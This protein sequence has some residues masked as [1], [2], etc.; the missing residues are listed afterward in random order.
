[1]ELL[2]SLLS[3]LSALD[4][5]TLDQEYSGAS[6]DNRY[7]ASQAPLSSTVTD[8]WRMI[9]Q[10]GVKVIVM[11]CREVEMG[12]RK[13]ECY[14]APVHRSTE[15]GPFT[16]NNVGKPYWDVSSHRPASVV[17]I[18]LQ[19]ITTDFSIMKIILELRRQRPSTVQTKEQYQFIFWS[20]VCMIERVLQSSSR[21]VYGNLPELKKQDKKTTVIS[22]SCNKRTLP[23]SHH[24]DYYPASVSAAPV[25]SCVR[26][27]AKPHSLPP[28][29]TPIYDTATPANHRPAEGSLS[30]HSN[31][32]YQLVPAKQLS[33][34]NEVYE[35][36]SPSVTN[37]SNI[38][39]PGGIESRI[40]TALSTGSFLSSEFTGLNVTTGEQFRASPGDIDNMK[41]LIG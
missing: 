40:A 41:R 39:S 16:I 2:P 9:W 37:M 15:F 17:S 10:H 32:A 5:D 36:F 34:E 35:E 21:Q 18:H 1:M 38:C 12:K 30:L 23:T 28:S 14:W 27:R 29:A 7:I 3:T 11:A 4:P 13:C 26:P 20:V 8:F 19:Q 24:Y 33:P 22:A 31:G 25:Y 6:A